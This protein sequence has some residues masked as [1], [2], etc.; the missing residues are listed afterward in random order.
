MTTTQATLMVH[1]GADRITREQLRGLDCPTPTDTWRPVPHADLIDALEARLDR[2]HFTIARQEYAVM[3][4]GLVLF[5]VLD[6]RNG[7]GRED[8][9]FAVGVRASNDK[10]VAIGLVAG[11]RVF[12]CDNLALSGDMILLK[13][14]HT[15]GL[16][17]SHEMD[18]GV[19]S[20]LAKTERLV[21]DLDRLAQEPIGDEAAK[22]TIF[23]AV[24]RGIVPQRL[25]PVVA[26]N[27]FEAEQREYLDCVPRTRFGLHNAFTR[28][29]KALAPAPAF[30][31]N[32]GLGTLFGLN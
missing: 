15:S 23:D 6:I 5:A 26:Q 10:S 29:L 2:A 8:L 17:L 31:A 22:V 27:F 30:K 19:V 9:G 14:K 18:R 7:I 24:Y 13:R 32:L 16:D 1:A 11:L 25:L 4:Q 20:Y 28:A 12:V 21:L 3:R